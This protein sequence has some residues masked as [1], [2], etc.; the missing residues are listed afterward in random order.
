GP[1]GEDLRQ[2]LGHRVEV[3]GQQLDLGAAVLASGRLGVDLAHGLRVQPGAAVLQVVARDAGDGGVV[4]VPGDHG[5][6]YPAGLVTV[7]R[8]RLAGVDL[9]EVAAPGALVATDQERGLAVLPALVDVRAAGFLADRVQ[10][11]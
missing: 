6:A 2:L 5:L 1:G 8:L 7:E 3:G 4:Q 10:T 11:L 9:A